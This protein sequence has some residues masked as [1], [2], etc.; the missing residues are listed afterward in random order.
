MRASSNV[1][2]H[3]KSLQLNLFFLIIT[4]MAD[5]KCMITQISWVRSVVVIEAVRHQGCVT[6]GQKL[7]L[8]HEQTLYALELKGIEIG[9][10]SR[11]RPGAGDHTLNLVFSITEQNSVYLKLA[12]AG[13]WIVSSH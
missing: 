7:F 9:T 12:Q 11:R 5:F 6:T 3:Q 4:I 13:D 2:A 10:H 1:M 8:Q